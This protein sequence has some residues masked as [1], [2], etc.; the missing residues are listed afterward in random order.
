[1]V[2]LLAVAVGAISST[3]WYLPWQCWPREALL[4][5]VP[6]SCALIVAANLVGPINPYRYELTLFGLF[7]WIGLACRRG[8]ALGA[9]PLLAITYLPP[10]WLTSH[11][12]RDAILGL[13]LMALHCVLIG[14]VLAWFVAHL[15][16]TQSALRQSEA[17]LR[18]IV[19]A[20][21]LP[22]LTMDLAGMV[23]SWNGA[24]EDTFGWRE[25][26]ILGK[27]L[28]QVQPDERAAFAELLAWLRARYCRR[29]RYG[30]FG[31]TA[32]RSICRSRPHRCVPAMDA[33][34]G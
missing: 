30:A 3:F 12:T 29:W 24:A 15:N 11:I 31:G 21:P 14:E 26:E 32:R 27:P 9:L 13:V 25:E 10:P 17:Q 33:S 23:Q 5:I 16:H 18:A 1:M 20:S 19:D 28:P 4:A 34:L 7:A 8:T 6:L 2:G 22:I